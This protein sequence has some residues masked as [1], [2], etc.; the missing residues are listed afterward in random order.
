MPRGR[1]GARGGRACCGG[2]GAR[3]G[4]DGGCGLADSRG[5]RGHRRVAG[6]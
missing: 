5:L 4:S 3:T 2:M 6:K 1:S